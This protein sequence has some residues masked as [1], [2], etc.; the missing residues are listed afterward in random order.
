[1]GINQC[2]RIIRIDTKPVRAA[3][4]A[5]VG[6]KLLDLDADDKVAAAIVI[7]PKDPKSSTEN[8]P[9]LR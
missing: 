1:M 7:P 3:G 5:T 6:V 8:G 4:R 9:L 2:G